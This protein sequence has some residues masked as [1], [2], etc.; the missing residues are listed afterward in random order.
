MVELAPVQVDVA[1]DDPLVQRGLGE[2]DAVFHALAVARGYHA[3][4]MVLETVARIVELAG[5]PRHAA[6]ASALRAAFAA[7]TGAFAPDDAWFE[8]R[9][10]A[11]WCD[12]VTTGQ[13][14]RAVEDELDEGPR[15]WLTPLER[16]HRGLFRVERGE[17][18]VLVDVWS[19]AELEVSVVEDASRAE[20]DASSGQLFDARVVGLDDP[21]TVALLPGAVFHSREATPCIEPVLAAARTR[22]L[23]GQETLD[24]LLRMQRA[25]RSLSRVKVAYAYRV[26]ALSPTATPLP[27]SSPRVARVAREP[28]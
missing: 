15:R 21:F 16:A 17:R 9:I 2:E 8:E 13:L 24:A 23:S 27:H 1:V 12:A 10:R 5:A 20:L 19:G 28:H 11:F 3:A 14:G 26:E 4:G 22:G 18:D 25:L 6:T 7:R